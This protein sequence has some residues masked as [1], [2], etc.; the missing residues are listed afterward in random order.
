VEEVEGAGDAL[1][2]LARLQLVQVAALLDVGQQGAAGDLLEDQVEVVLLLEV[3]VHLK[4]A[5]L[6]PT[7]V[8]D[9]NLLEHLAA[10]PNCVLLYLLQADK[11]N[12]IRHES[13]SSGG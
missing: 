10:A 12:D 5:V 6:A 4:D 3:L 8:E 13:L 1:D 7:H 2:N 11:G 9:L